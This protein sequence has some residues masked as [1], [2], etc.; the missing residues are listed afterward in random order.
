MNAAY[1]FGGFK[2]LDTAQAVLPCL[3]SAKAL[4]FEQASV[5][6]ALNYEKRKS[7]PHSQRTCLS[8]GA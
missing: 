6:C 2:L 7:F 4:F 5:W 1:A 8:S 3:S